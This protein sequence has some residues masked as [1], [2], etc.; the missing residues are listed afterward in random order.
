MTE[1]NKGK[2]KQDLKFEGQSIKLSE[3]K[4]V[5][6]LESFLE[7]LGQSRLADLIDRYAFLQTLTEKSVYIA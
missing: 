7:V 1:L 3:V 2:A 5:S 6:K 4:S